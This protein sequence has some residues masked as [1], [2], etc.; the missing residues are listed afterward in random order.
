M[1]SRVAR[2][3]LL[4]LSLLVLLLLLLVS[5]CWTGPSAT[6]AAVAE[7]SKLRSSDAFSGL[8]DAPAAQQPR[9]TRRSRA[10]LPY[11]QPLPRSTRTRVTRP[12]SGVGQR[13]RSAGEAGNKRD[14]QL[15]DTKELTKASGPQLATSHFMHRAARGNRQYDVPQIGEYL[16]PN[17]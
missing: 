10:P 4:P 8:L 6:A 14:P 15:P 3:P 2:P 5:S 13:G 7:S 12:R 1:T 17:C 11:E 16:P 9:L